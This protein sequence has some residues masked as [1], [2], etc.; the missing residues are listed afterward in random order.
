M[1]GT[2][3]LCQLP[4]SR[5]LFSDHER[6]LFNYFL[7]VPTQILKHVK[8]WR[9]LDGK[10]VFIFSSARRKKYLATSKEIGSFIICASTQQQQQQ[11][12]QL[13]SCRV[14]LTW[15]DFMYNIVVRTLGGRKEGSSLDN[16]PFSVFE[17]GFCNFIKVQSKSNLSM[18]N[19]I[20]MGGFCHIR[21]SRTQKNKGFYERLSQT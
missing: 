12:Q 14:P 20:P 19:I 6:I 10:S 17:P 21:F 3:I 18:Q 15:A 5:P 8:I 2:H 1:L 11:Q 7:F 16:S 4:I 9:K 13:T